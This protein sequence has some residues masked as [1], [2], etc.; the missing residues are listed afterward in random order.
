MLKWEKISDIWKG[1]LRGEIQTLI[2]C[3]KIID[4]VHHNKY[5][6]AEVNLLHA[7]HYCKGWLRISTKFLACV[8]LY[9]QYL[10]IFRMFQWIFHNLKTPPFKT[11]FGTSES[12]WK[13][14]FLDHGHEF[15]PKRWFRLSLQILWYLYSSQFSVISDMLFFN[16]QSNLVICGLNFL[17][18]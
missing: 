10:F 14:H 12:E 13:S 9:L 18:K 11:S 1:K 2:G 16:F 7:Y 4:L 5:L 15:G 3:R 17:N 6:L 8:I